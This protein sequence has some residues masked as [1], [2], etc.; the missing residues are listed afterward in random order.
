MIDVEQILKETGAILQGHFLL[1]NGLH[2]DTQIQFAKAVQYTW[3]AKEIAS[4]LALKLHRFAPD[5][6]ASPVTNGMTV[7]YEVARNLDVPFIFS[8]QNANGTM[9]FSRGL[10]PS[11]FR[12]IVIVEGVVEDGK[13]VR[14]LLST[15]KKF[16]SEAIAVSSVVKRAD[17]KKIEGL[18][19]L[20]LATIPLNLYKPK[21]CPMCKKG[22]PIVNVERS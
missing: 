16:D 15:L 5:C 1:S 12:N 18:S 14:E 4:E 21:E 3:Y 17:I 10:D 13:S 2:T 7:G 22:I 20:S 8:E 11:I 6:I 19:L 9:T